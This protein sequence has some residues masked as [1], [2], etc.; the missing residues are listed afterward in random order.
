MQYNENSTIH[1]NVSE[2]TH[3]DLKVIENDNNNSNPHLSEIITV[4]K[5][6]EAKGLFSKTS[7]EGVKEF[8]Y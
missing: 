2:N 1:K 8:L 5:V 4:E 6:R 7:G 3:I